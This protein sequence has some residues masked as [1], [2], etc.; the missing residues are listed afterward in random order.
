ML[1]GRNDDDEIKADL[2]SSV[3]K[4]VVYI[5]SDLYLSWYIP[6]MEERNLIY[7]NDKTSSVL[8][9]FFS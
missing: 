1:W 9:L 2:E 8:I 5:S 4:N 3:A 7:I 6:L